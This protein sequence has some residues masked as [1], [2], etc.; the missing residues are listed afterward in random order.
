[1][2]GKAINGKSFGACV[3]YC[4]DEQKS[5]EILDTNGIMIGSKKEITQQFNAIRK[6]RPQV[7]K[8]VWHTPIAFAISDKVDNELMQTI[9][10]DY[11]KEM[12]LMNNQYLVVKHND[13]R[14]PHMHLIINR[15]GYDGEAVSDRFNSVRTMKVMQKFEKKYGLT[16]AIEQGNIRKMTIKSEIK[17][18]IKRRESFD[19]TMK[20]IKTMGYEITINKTSK[21][22]LNGVSFKH[23]DDKIIYKASQIDRSLPR[24]LKTLH[25]ALEQQHEMTR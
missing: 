8:A 24:M 1:M 19:Q 3:N 10:R 21:G 20:R 18:S 7:S 6:L 17:T 22:K 13:T 12:K 16:V 14:H 15:I 23:S 2:I 5:P 25:Q 11:I 4:L 9:S